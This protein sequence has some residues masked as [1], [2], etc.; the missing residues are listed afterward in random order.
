MGWPRRP[1]PQ[2]RIWII[3][4][5]N[6]PEKGTA[7]YKKDRELARHSDKNV[8]MALASRE[9]VKSEILYFL[10]E[11]KS[12]EVR[13]TI[14]ANA[15]AP[16][17]ANLALARDDNEQV[18][19]DLAS[20][21]AR[22]VPDLCADE[23][24]K[25]RRSTYETLDILARDQ[26]T[27]VRQIISDTLKDVADAPPD[28]I[29]SLALDSEVAVASPVLEFSPVLTDEMLLEIIEAN[30]A[31]A[32]LSA[33]SRRSLVNENVADAIAT[34]DNIEAI[35]ELLGNPSAQL[36][37]ETLD[38]LI[39]RAPSIELWHSPLVARPKLSAGA[40]QRM[41]YFLADNLLETLQSREDLDAETLD[42]VKTVVQH[43]I[44]KGTDKSEEHAGYEMDY[45]KVGLLL[46]TARQLNLA[47]KLDS[48]MIGKSIHAGDYEFAMAAMIVRS[49]LSLNVVEKI[50]SAHSA[51]GI[52]AVAWKAG[53]SMKVAYYVQQRIAHIAPS[54][55]IEATR[56]DDYT[57]S[58]DEMNWQL[59][60]FRDLSTKRGCR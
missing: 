7:T 56:G 47:G 58:E 41:A 11:D 18:R 35:A 38:D 57:F 27:M 6:S 29:N 55:I 19:A 54:E 49:E 44:G 34:T 21:I 51:K 24:D 39:E 33:I 13:R 46:S 59:E 4:V 43:R 20:K 53:L 25:L 45:T 48:K 22:A 30:P 3:P 37:E 12:A 10:A 2:A 26:I 28:L 17:Q 32:G 14:A 9:D 31:S 36:R 40:A 8:R 50:F 15:S 5:N 42:A 52:V 16:R 1:T 23:Q 60:F